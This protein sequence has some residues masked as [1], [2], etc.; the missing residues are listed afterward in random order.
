MEIVSDQIRPVSDR[1]T[2]GSNEWSEGKEELLMRG[3]CCTI[4]ETYDS[5]VKFPRI[6][7]QICAEVI[8]QT[9][10]PWHEQPENNT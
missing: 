9:P 10:S 1:I 5:C 3:N 8:F 6:K 7:I 2:Y 4:T